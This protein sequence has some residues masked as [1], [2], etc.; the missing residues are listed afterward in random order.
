M[1]AT[2]Q[3]ARVVSRILPTLRASVTAITLASAAV[4]LS[5]CSTAGGGGVGGTSA[6]CEEPRISIT[7]TTASPGDTVVVR[8]EGWAPCIDSPDE[9]AEPA[10]SQVSLEWTLGSLWWDAEAAQV[11]DAT[12]EIPLT[13]PLDADKGGVMVK[14]SVLG[15]DFVA[16]APLVLT[17]PGQE[18]AQGSGETVIFDGTIDV[19]YG[20]L[21]M[22]SVPGEF[23]PEPDAAMRGQSNGLLGGAVPG[24]LFMRTGLHTG[25]VPLRIVLADSPP[26]LGSWEEI[27]EVSFQPVTSELTLMTFDDAIDLWLPEGDYRVR[28]SATGLDAGHDQDTVLEGERSPDSYQLS[29][30]PAPSRSDEILRI[31]GS[32]AR[33]AHAG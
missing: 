7:P 9:P 17:I 28:W 20:F 29:F 24:G 14:A 25:S 19:H 30:W 18:G 5:A 6:S 1:R 8:G 4:C 10:W 31:T 2:L 13:V 26:P 22:S 15:Q 33:L 16:S 27:V 12:F 32:E 21:T 3:Y 23:G 11:V